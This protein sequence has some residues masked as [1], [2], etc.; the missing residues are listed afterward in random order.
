MTNDI[1]S[2][3][4]Y[5]SPDPAYNTMYDNETPLNYSPQMTSAYYNSMPE[6][7]EDPTYGYDDG[8]YGDQY[9]YANQPMEYDD[10][11]NTYQSMDPTIIN[12]QSSTLQPLTPAPQPYYPPTQSRSDLAVPTP[13]MSPMEMIQDYLSKSQYQSTPTGDTNSNNE[14]NNQNSQIQASSMSN[15]QPSQPS[16]PPME[17]IQDKFSKNEYQSPP[18]GEINSNNGNNNQNNQIQTSSMSNSQPSQSSMTPIEIIEDQL[19]KNQF[20][21]TPTGE[22]ISQPSQPSISQMDMIQG[23]SFNN[24]YQ[25]TPTGETNSNYGNNN[26]NNPIQAASSMSSLQPPPSLKTPIEIIQDQL[27]KSPQSLQSQVQPNFELKPLDQISTNSNNQEK[28]PE[29][30]ASPI[31][32]FTS[33]LSNP[34]SQ[35]NLPQDT[36][37]IN[38]P[39]IFQSQPSFITDQ[40]VMPSN[41]DFQTNNFFKTEPQADSINDLSSNPLPDSGNAKSVMEMNLENYFTLPQPQNQLGTPNKENNK[42]DN[43]EFDESGILN[44]LAKYDKSYNVDLESSKIG[45]EDQNDLLIF[46][47][48]NDIHVQKLPPVQSTSIT[49]TDVPDNNDLFTTLPTSNPQ[50]KYNDAFNL[51]QLL[52]SLFMYNQNKIF[53]NQQPTGMFN[54]FYNNPL[55]TNV[56]KK[57]DTLTNVKPSSA[58]DNNGYNY[59]QIDLTSPSLYTSSWSLLKPNYNP[60]NQQP[61]RNNVNKN[62]NSS[63]NTPERPLQYSQNYNQDVSIPPLNNFSMKNTV[64]TISNTMYVPSGA[65]KVI[66]DVTR[67]NFPNIPVIQ[68]IQLTYVI[69]KSIA[70]GLRKIFIKKSNILFSVSSS[71]NVTSY[72]HIFVV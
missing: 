48:P 17:V 1:N 36:N 9:Q 42:L 71:R 57:Q 41:N 20:Q 47:N 18:M 13:P 35:I 70:R 66:F 11:L 58:T 62:I 6:S 68:Q 29:Q 53:P 45:K 15:L 52:S 23:Q 61:S 7:L 5:P 8:T 25:S 63:K 34:L 51:N 27:F 54:N 44:E 65:T 46:A 22:K 4:N 49:E 3:Y 56:D 10:Y 50:P 19:Y 69:T 40:N 60:I 14:Y 72:S 21:S 55:N 24:Q 31:P 32:F 38:K 67:A 43:L 2:Y 30:V 59:K 64:A 16:T 28:K 39:I 12:S 37:S 26:Q 33:P